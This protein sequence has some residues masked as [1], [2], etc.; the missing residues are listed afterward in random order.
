MLH[1]VYSVNTV[2]TY[3]KGSPGKYTITMRFVY[4]LVSLLIC[5]MPLGVFAFEQIRSFDARID[6]ETDATI[7]VREQIVYDFSTLERHGIFRQIPFSYQASS[8]TYTAPISSVTVTDADGTP[9]RFQESRTGSELTL[10]I[11]D[12][13]VTV[14]GE[15]TYII[16][17][18]VTGP[19]LY[20]TDRDEL[21]WNVVGSWSVPID[22]AS[23][24]VN[25]PLDT[26]VLDAACYQGVQGSV[27][28]CDEGTRLISDE[29]AGYH[30]AANELAT[31]E[32][33]SVAVAFP[34]G[35]IAVVQRPWERTPQRSMWSYW[36]L[37]L[38]LAVFLFMARLWYTRGR[39]P[40]GRTTIVTQFEPPHD[41]TPSMAG[42]VYN[43]RIEP[44]EISAEI[45]RLA[46]DGYIKIHRIDKE[47][48][49]LTTTDYLL[50]RMQAEKTPDDT[51]QALILEQ[52]FQSEFLGTAEVD[53][54]RI[55][56]VMLSK[57]KQKFARELE[58]IEDALYAE[59]YDR[60]Y[61][62]E[63]PDKVRKRF[64]LGGIVLMF[65]GAG[66]ALM[67]QH[68]TLVLLGIGVAV[69]GAMIGLWGL[70]MPAK[71]REGVRVK[72]HLEGFKRYVGVAEKDRIA[73]HNAP[74]RTPELFDAMVPYAV[75]YGVEK[76]W[77]RQFEDI[78]ATEPRWYHGVDGESFSP[79]SFTSDISAFS[80]DF[81]AASAPSSSG[82]SGGGSVGG[83][84]GGG[85]GGSW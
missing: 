65:V 40:E 32:G 58:I 7:H 71:T 3:G 56:G 49:F 62:I 60:G 5:A 28:T 41:M 37:I 1:N 51:L 4:F 33:F 57:M 19:F 10:K 83:G 50:E 78:Y 18:S 42:V 8:T 9:R 79:S 67:L 66:A 21:Y 77:A 24:L 47:V 72:E 27:E 70:I 48:L 85:G 52:L 35:T 69:S 22:R 25:L 43:E 63:R 76:E 34:K 17:Y 13:D 20:F 6:V 38:P 73:F 74:E 39:D 75:V 81:S 84:F 29:R 14:S 45:I 53:G 54:G 11:G 31:Q 55:E 44:R 82:S 46:V 64:S 80:S 16:T 15:Q 36:P 2:K 26:T 30:A 61:F 12:P 23:V 68:F 59:V